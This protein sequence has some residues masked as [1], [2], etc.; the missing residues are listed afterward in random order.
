MNGTD[1]WP[2]AEILSI[3]EHPSYRTFYV[4]YVD[5]KFRRVSEFGQDVR[6]RMW[7]SERN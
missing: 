2:L 3:K 6:V 4:H 7:S 5:C 1:D